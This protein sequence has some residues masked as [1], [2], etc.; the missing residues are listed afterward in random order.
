M[1]YNYEIN[2]ENQT[3]I[4]KTIGDIITKEIVAMGLEIMMIAKELNCKIVYDYRLSNRISVDEAYNWFSTH[5]E[6]IDCE[7]RRIPTA[8]IVNIDDWEFYS[9]FE[10]TSNNKGITIKAFQDEN[11]CLRWLK[12]Y[13]NLK[14]VNALCKIMF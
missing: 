12:I 6:N 14:T 10:C 5:Y 8:Y 9:F 1:K 2:S 7:F 4:V 13:E 11:D 3:I